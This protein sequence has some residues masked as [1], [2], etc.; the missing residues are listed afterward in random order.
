MKTRNEK[1]RVY[2]TFA[3]L[4]LLPVVMV[5]M[6]ACVADAYDERLMPNQP[7]APV[8][9]KIVYASA[10]TA[11]SRL[12][13][14]E[15]DDNLS[16]VWSEKDAFS[17]FGDN[18][19]SHTFYIDS[20]STDNHHRASFVGVIPDSTRTGTTFYAVYPGLNDTVSLS[21][22][23]IDLSEQS[24]RPDST[25]VV[26]MWAKATYEEGR[27]LQFDFSNLTAMLKL[28][29]RFPDYVTEAKD[30]KLKGLRS[31]GTIDILQGVI[32]NL[33]EDDS[34][35][36]SRNSVF[37]TTNHTLTVCV[38]LLPQARPRT[39]AIIAKSTDGNDTYT[40]TLTTDHTEELQS[41]CLYSTKE[42]E[43]VKKP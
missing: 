24:G 31:K 17:V 1:N 12:A 18:L 43:M 21:A 34:I 16:I 35:L 36:I 37:P 6:M 33:Q 32:S 41:G 30:I 25:L 13:F 22:S 7:M 38:S 20:L 8:G 4:A 39:I 5:V 11:D 27:N 26:Y 2:Y 40:G 28:T 29:L 19:I 42:V 3:K 23:G 14:N 9:M 10:G 15:T